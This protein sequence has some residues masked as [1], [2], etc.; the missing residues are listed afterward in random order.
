MEIVAS[1]LTDRRSAVS[2]NDRGADGAAY[3]RW[4]GWV[5][6]TPFGHLSAG[7]ADYFKRELR[8]VTGGAA[9]Q[10]VLEIGFG[11]GAFLSYCRSREWTVTGTELGTDL[12]A[13]AREAGFDVHP[14]DEL[15]QVPDGS[16]DLVAV[17]DVLEHIPQD[18]IIEFLESLAAK[19]RP[20]GS[21]LLRFPNADSWLGNPLQFGDPTHVTAIGYLKMSYFALC[22][23]LRLDVFRAATR[24]SFASS[25]VHGLYSLTAGTYIDVTARLKQLIY[26]P[27]LPVVLSTSN[28]ICVARKAP[29]RND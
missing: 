24:P 27:G 8:D 22:A 29:S 28:V 5:A 15:D 6:E 12:V 20:N 13:A 17:F 18:D 9:V 19:L 26:F 14:A 25:F 21:M 16:F 1:T 2:Y 3:S 7:E 23:G 10:D 4:K 11:N